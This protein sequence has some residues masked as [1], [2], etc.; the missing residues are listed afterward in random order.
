MPEP[1]C[2]ATESASFG[3]VKD[4][5][6]AG[7]AKVLSIVVARN[8]T[9]RAIARSAGGRGRAALRVP[10]SHS[11]FIAPITDRQFEIEFLDSGMQ[12]AYQ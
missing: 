11:E 12:E 2:Q 4:G 1:Q 7:G 3:C 10:H 9:R 8:R 6:G 5:C